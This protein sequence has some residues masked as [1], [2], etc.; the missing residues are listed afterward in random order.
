MVL[1]FIA[2]LLVVAGLVARERGLRLAATHPSSSFASKSGIQAS[3]FGLLLA[4]V[5]A[6]WVLIGYFTSH[7]V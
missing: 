6:P 3:G 5:G 1:A 7:I 2:T 4:V